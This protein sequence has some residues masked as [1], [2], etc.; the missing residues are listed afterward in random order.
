MSMVNS[1]SK[2]IRATV[3][4]TATAAVILA[5]ISAFF[6]A[7]SLN[8]KAA[9]DRAQAMATLAA[10][11]APGALSLRDNVR[12]RELLAAFSATKNVLAARLLDNAN[13]V[14]AEYAKAGEKIDGNLFNQ[15]PTST[16]VARARV[17]YEGDNLGSVEVVVDAEFLPEMSLFFLLA[18]LSV[19]GL[20]LAAVWFVAGP[21]EKRISRPIASLS[22]FT[23]RVRDSKD[24]A[25]R[26]PMSPVRE[27]RG[28]TED[29]NEMLGVIERAKAEQDERSTVLSKLAFYDQLTGAAN[30]SL[31]RDRLSACVND[32]NQKRQPFSLIGID[33]DNFKSLNDTHGH[34]TGDDYLREASKRCM[35]LL[36]PND[37][38]ARMGGDEFVVLLP[39]IDKQSDAMAVAEKLAE[40]IR[41]ANKIHGHATVCTASIGVGLYPFDAK[42]PTEL[43][44]K[45]DAA[46]YRAKSN[47]RDQVVPVTDP[48][49]FNNDRPQPIQSD[50][51]RYTG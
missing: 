22:V 1:F 9:G 40:G 29:L 30:R 36:R 51:T 17:Q 19:I 4:G 18:A 25:L 26:I 12:G 16:R 31:F 8:Q 24:Y 10:A 37:T 23:R 28:L 20:L 32:F 34:N 6:I 50:F 2:Q 3:V 38:F 48:S 13:T 41:K 5:V 33:L 14:L 39:G 7:A 46:M 21:L 43:V 11:S 15:P 45:V 44:S 47:G 42:N 27:L 35:A 49:T